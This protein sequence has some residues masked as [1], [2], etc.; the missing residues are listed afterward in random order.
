M[1]GV[2]V[3][4]VA[5]A[6]FACSRPGSTAGP[7]TPPGAK[8]PAADTATAAPNACAAI[9]EET[10]KGPLRWFHDDYP[11]AV[12][13]AKAGDKPLLI[14]MWAPWCHTC[15]S[16]KSYVLADPG[17]TPLADRFVWLSV[18]TDKEQNAPLLEKFPVSAWPTFFVVSPADEAVQARYVGS[19]SLAQFREFLAEGEK[20]HLASSAQSLPPE[21]PLLLVRAADRAALARDWKAADEAYGRALGK[22]PP[23]WSRR[24]DVLVSRIS[25][26]YRQ[27]DWQGC[28]AL[29]AAAMEQTGRSASALDFAFFASTCAYQLEDA[30]AKRALL[31]LSAKRIGEVVEDPAA[32]LSVDDRSDGLRILRDIR[33]HMGDQSGAVATA[34]KQRQML[35]EAAATAPDAFAAMT[36]NWPRAEVYVYL[37]IAEKLVPALQQSVADLPQEYDPPYRLAWIYLNLE[38]YDEALAMAEKALALAYGPRKARVQALI[39]EIHAAAGNKAA[40]REALEAVVK[41]YESLPAGQKQPEAEERA[42]SALQA[43]Q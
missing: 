36:Y 19:A 21:S 30:S 26:R 32:P 15:L 6:G 27:Q 11:S 25:V 1:A 22:A 35:D 39:A 37:G 16:M 4:L 38:R 8:S 40:R 43:A 24:P 31:E 20:T 14:D 9:E 33:E 2:L 28:A 18:D 34:K 41:I 12:A 42:R 29:G 5:W 3:L 23:D 17:I 7:Q 13:C 10:G